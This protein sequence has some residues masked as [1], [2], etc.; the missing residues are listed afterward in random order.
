[1]PLFDF[2]C[3]D[4]KNA[5]EYLVGIHDSPPVCPCGAQMVKQI[6][7]PRLNVNHWVPNPLEMNAEKEAIAAGMYE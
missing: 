5:D 2:V 1:M 3:P 7:I 6:G 4:C